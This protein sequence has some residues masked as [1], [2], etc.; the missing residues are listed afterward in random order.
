MIKEIL[1][2]NMIREPEDIQNRVR[3]TLGPIQTLH[4][5]V[6]QLIMR[7]DNDEKF[8]KDWNWLIKSNLTERVQQSIDTLILLAKA[9]DTKIDDKMFCVEDFIKDNNLKI[10]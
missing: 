4:D 6:E 2:D 10:E 1:I 3:N 7:Y 9:A 5:I 8:A